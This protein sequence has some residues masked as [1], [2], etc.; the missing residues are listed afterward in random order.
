MQKEIVFTELQTEYIHY[1]NL[2]EEQRQKIKF[3]REQVKFKRDLYQHNLIEL[4]IKQNQTQ[5]HDIPKQIPFDD[6]SQAN[7]QFRQTKIQ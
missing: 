5:Q 3:L 4:L 2:I 6:Q 1:F 7:S